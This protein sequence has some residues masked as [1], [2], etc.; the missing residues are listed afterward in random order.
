M[1]ISHYLPD[2]MKFIA[3]LILPLFLFSCYISPDGLPPD[4][5][6]WEYDQPDNVGFSNSEL[7]TINSDIALDVY[8]FVD[9]LIII[10][11]NKLIFE[12]YYHDLSRQSRISIGRGTLAFT[13]NAIGI[14]IEQGVLNL[15]DAIY[16]HLPEYA[17]IFEAD[18]LKKNITIAHLLA[19][20]GGFS[21]NETIP[22]SDP[23]NNDLA[24]MRNS[25]DWIRYILNQP[26]EASPGLRF[27]MNSG[28]GIILAKILKNTTGMR[29][30]DFLT[31][32]VF[33]PLTITSISFDLDN[34][35]NID[36]GSGA[37]LTLL[38][39]T[40]FGHLMLENGIW[41]GRRIVDPN[42]IKESTTVQSPVSR[43]Y[44][45]GYAWWL[46][47]DSFENSYRFDKDDVFFISGESGQHLYI[48]PTEKMI[49][50]IH[51]QNFLFGFNTPSL[52]LFS[53]IAK[54]LTS[55]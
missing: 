39:W 43:H 21:W 8:G 45:L 14:A 22:P 10:K 9:G 15:Q 35:G 33:T 36:G 50:S 49:I 4:Q 37:S 38:D 32:E 6:I 1:A 48:V 41:R 51:A 2:I 53:D 55:K 17:S 54:I 20:R 24:Q 19:H 27:N 11:D 25:D 31:N 29:M 47:G 28:T 40:K 26:L 23:G 5:Q 34:A 3:Y 18:V 12:N 46:F 52:S 7:L 44:N 42:F 16:T 13:V 30:D